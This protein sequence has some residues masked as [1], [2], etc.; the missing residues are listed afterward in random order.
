VAIPLGAWEKPAYS[1][2]AGGIRAVIKPTD[3]QLACHTIMYDR[4]EIPL[5][6]EFLTGGEDQPFIVNRKAEIGFVLRQIAQ[7]GTRV[8]LYY[9]GGRGFIL[10]TIMNVNDPWIYLETV[11]DE[12]QNLELARSLPLVFVSS[13]QQA[14]IQFGADHADLMPYNGTKMFRLPLP[15]SLLRI[16]R[17][18]YFRLMLPTSQPLYCVIPRYG[19]NSSASNAMTIVNISVGGIAVAR[20]V[21]DT[22]LQLGKSYDNCRIELPEDIAIVTSIQ[23]RNML[24]TTPPFRSRLKQ[25]GCQF[26][27]LDN[28]TAVQL[29]RYI[30]EHQTSE[31]KW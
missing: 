20:D 8:A 1:T 11:P 22:E 14:K 30:N 16:Q 29:Q 13:H 5:N 6:I 4:Y 2:N 21:Q 25:I 7:K 23:V 26:V 28:A 17:R 19:D 3:I 10:T 24:V 31:R 9:D 15:S 12:A 18:N 27:K